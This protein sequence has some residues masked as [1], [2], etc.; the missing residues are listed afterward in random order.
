MDVETLF[1]KYEDEHLNFKRIPVED[2]LSEDAT[3]CALLYIYNLMT[4]FWLFK[5]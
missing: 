1:E 4:F 2:R 3:L 5:L